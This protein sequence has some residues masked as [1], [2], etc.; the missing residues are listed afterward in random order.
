M[1][2]YQLHYFLEAARQKNFTRA[3]ARLHLA[4]AALSEQIRKLERELGTP[5]FNRGRHGAT[6]TGAGE[7]LKP[8][9]EAL[10]DRAEAARREVSD[11]AGLRGGRVCLGSIP[12]VS[13]CLLPEAIATFRKLH[14]AVELAVLEGTSEAVAHWVETGRLEFGIVQLPARVGAFEVKVL[15]KESFV[16]LVGKDHGLA[17]RRRVAL[18]AV[19]EESFIVYKGRAHDSAMAACRAAGFEPRIACESGELETI[20]SLV[21][22]G[23]GVALLPR[24]AARQPSPR[25]V[26]LELKGSPVERSV[27]LLHCAGHTLSPG[28]R[29]FYQLL[30]ENPAF[31]ARSNRSGRRSALKE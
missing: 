22:A 25:C 20:R 23:L 8:H 3:A 15:L 11:Y 31:G 18:E 1:E 16:L 13:A 10:L 26:A 7:I 2:L 30:T 29:V 17:A 28:A 6:L 5:L 9:A 21:A 27:A 24:L 4:Q 12:S 14:P 19:G